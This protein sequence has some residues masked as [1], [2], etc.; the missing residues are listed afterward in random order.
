ML[1]NELRRHPDKNPRRSTLEELKLAAEQSGVDKDLL[2]VTFTDIN[3][4]GVNPRTKYKT[5]LGVYAYPYKYVMQRNIVSVPFAERSKYI[6]LISAENCQAWMIDGPTEYAKIFFGQSHAAH[7][8]DIKILGA[9]H[10][11]DVFDYMFYYA[12]DKHIYIGEKEHDAWSQ[13]YNVAADELGLVHARKHGKLTAKESLQISAMVTKIIRSMNI[14]VVVD[15]GYGVIHENE[16]CQALFVTPAKIKQITTI[17]NRA[18]YEQVLQRT[19]RESQSWSPGDRLRAKVEKA[20][21]LH[22]RNPAIERSIDKMIGERDGVVFAL[23]QAESYAMVF[24]T[25]EKRTAYIKHIDDMVMA[26]FEV[27]LARAGLSETIL[28][29]LYN[30]GA[31]F[32]TRMISFETLVK[33]LPSTSSIERMVRHYRLT[34]GI[35]PPASG[36]KTDEN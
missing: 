15:P 20:V 21:A 36:D 10:N 32:K 31:W 30:L 9:A 3:K 24:D 7:L 35:T 17:K 18:H 33:E 6:Q 23:V 22:T 29:T 8:T 13:I 27:A 34:L 28:S 25:S 19:D 1:L 16:P 5:P 26:N 14:D 2:F 4:V 11:E 12:R